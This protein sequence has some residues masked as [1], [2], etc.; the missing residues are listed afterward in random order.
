MRP[1]SHGTDLPHPPAITSCALSRPVV[2]PRPARPHGRDG[3]E[4]NARLRFGNEVDSRES[5]E[6]SNRRR[7]RTVAT[8]PSSTRRRAGRTE[9]SLPHTLL[10]PS[11]R[12][13]AHGAAADRRLRRATG[14]PTSGTSIRRAR[15]PDSYPLRSQT[16]GRRSQNRDPA[17]RTQLACVR[18]HTKKFAET[19]YRPRWPP[20]WSGMV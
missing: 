8:N 6:S 3:R 18:S 14:G 10:R 19:A 15:I 20:L 7:C 4:S 2:L 11:L 9:P 5:S 16:H 17:P 1:R 12:Q 13:I